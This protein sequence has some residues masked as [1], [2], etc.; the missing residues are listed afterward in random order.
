[1]H[2]T[3]A[4]RKRKTNRATR[5]LKHPG[6]GISYPRHEKSITHPKVKVGIPTPVK[7]ARDTQKSLCHYTH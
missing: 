1:M 4:A 7:N 2:Y 6:L 5:S 3:S